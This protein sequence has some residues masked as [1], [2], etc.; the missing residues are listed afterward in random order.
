M[1]L[2]GILLAALSGACNGLF[3]APMKLQSRFKW[4]NTWL[5]FILVACIAMPMIIVSST[6]PQWP[7]LFSQAPSGAVLAAL[8]FGFAWG[9]GA[10]CFGQSVASLG[11]SIANSLVIGISSALGSLVPLI[12]GGS[13]RM[14]SRIFTL[15][16]GVIVF[17]IGVA[18]CGAAGM[19]RD[20]ATMRDEGAKA[21]TR[22]YVFAIAAGVMSAIFNIGFTLALPIAGEGKAMGLSPFAATNCIW[23]LMLGAG[24]IPNIVY[25][26]LLMRKNGTARLLTGPS[27]ARGWLLALIMGLLWG[28]SIFLYGAAV[29]KLGDIGPSIGWPLSLAV[30]LAVANAMGLL[31]GEWKGAPLAGHRANEVGLTAPVDCDR[32]VRLIDDNGRMTI[33]ES[34]RALEGKL[35][36]SCQADEKGAFHGAMDRYALAAVTGGAAGIRA[37]GPEDIRAIRL[38]VSVP[39]IGIQKSVHSD[40]KILITPSFESARELVEADATMIA[41]DCTRRG[42]RLGAFE[43]MRRIRTELLVPVLADIAT[44]EEA[45]EAVAAGADMVLSTMRGYTEETLHVSAFD[46]VFIRQLVRAVRVP[47]IAEGRVDT[48]ALARQAIRAGAFSVVVGTA[49]TRPHIITQNFA[50]SIEDEFERRTGSQA[51]LGIDMGG[52]NTKLGL[53]SNRGELLWQDTIPTPAH[54]GREGLLAHL[55]RVAAEGLERSRKF[56]REPVGI[57]IAT[58]GWVN[59]STGAVAYATENLP[60]W[61]GARDR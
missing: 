51:I 38:A 56:G 6:V 49:I 22:G 4:E 17:L 41:L 24:S 27:A 30:G 5:V 9:F 3:T 50:A 43:R 29:P 58:A 45:V 34:C 39:I 28:G 15:F 2:G 25:C 8:A 11:V 14:S 31:L 1:N 48:P 37:N 44:V 12:L 57:G 46:P 21:P 10:I 61:T 53:V 26:L 42:R 60:G 19:L 55:Q 54:S 52:T 35:I 33:P 40:G 20:K 7:Q 32:V 59:P 36:V 13:M 16:A 18:L 23:L 47:V